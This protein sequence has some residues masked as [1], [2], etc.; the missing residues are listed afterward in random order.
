MM[1]WRG[2]VQDHEIDL[3]QI[4]NNSFYLQYFDRA[5]VQGL[6]EIGIDWEVWHHK[7]FNIVLVHTDMTL[8]KSLKARDQFYVKSTYEKS[9]KLKIIF[10]Q[11]I[12]L[13]GTDQLIAK[14]VN[15]LVVVDINS[16]KPVAPN[17][18]NL[19]I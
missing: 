8:K 5:R 10:H 1:I 3:Q 14:A 4:V 17:E 7:G 11:E 6:K 2:E 12:Y 13:A 16:E 9:G 19:I 18:I 15:T